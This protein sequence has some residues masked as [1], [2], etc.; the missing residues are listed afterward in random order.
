MAGAALLDKPVSIR[1]S[2]GVKCG[3]V[4]TRAKKG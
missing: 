4:V 3:L 1:L 2:A